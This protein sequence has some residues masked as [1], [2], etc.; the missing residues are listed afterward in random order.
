MKKKI[1]VFSML[2]ALSTAAYPSAWGDMRYIDQLVQDKEYDMAKEELLDFLGKYSDSKKY[3]PVALDRLAKLYYLDKNYEEARNYFKEYLKSQNLKED[4][5][6][7]GIYNLVR[8]DIELENYEEAKKYAD[9]ITS[10]KKYLAFFQ[11]A[12]AFYDKENYDDAQ[13]Y[14]RRLLKFD[15]QYYQEGLLYLSLTSYKKN[16]YLKSIV[17]GEEYLSKAEGGDKNISLMNF[18]LGSSHLKISDLPVAENYFKTIENESPDSEYADDSKYQLFKLYIEQKRNKEYLEY[19][20]KLKGTQYENQGYL[21]MAQLY[22]GKEEYL[23]AEEYYGVLVKKESNPETVYGYAQTLFKQ[24]KNQQALMELKKLKGTEYDS[25]YYYYSSYILYGDKKYKDVLALLGNYEKKGI[26][27]EYLKNIEVFMGTSAYETGAYDTAKKYFEKAYSQE[28]NKD[29][30]YNLALVNSKMKNLKELKEN[31]SDYMEKY[32]KEFKYKKNLYILLGNTYFD[33]GQLDGAEKLYEAF[34]KENYDEEIL[35]NLISVLSKQGNYSK[36]LLYLEKA[37]PSVENMYLKGVSHLGLN[38]YE[39]AETAFLWVISSDRATADQKERASFRLIKDY[40]AWEEYEKAVEYGEKHVEKYKNYYYESMDMMAIAYFKMGSY[41]N[42]RS[43]YEKFLKDPKWAEY[44]AFQIAETYYN[45]ENYLDA[46]KQYEKL[47]SKNG[48]YAEDSLYWIIS[49]DY[50]Q[51][52]FDQAFKKIE[53]LKQR[54]PKSKYEQEVSYIKGEIYIAKN[55]ADQA[56]AEYEKLYEKTKEFSIGQKTAEK[57]IG[58]HYGAGAYSKALEWSSKLKDSK[59]ADLWKAAV[60]QKQG[61]TEE[62]L[63]GYEK[64]A[65]DSEYGDKA[66]FALGE[67]YLEAGNTQEALS[68]Y[69][70]VLEFETSGLKDKALFKMGDLHLEN[71]NHME[72][73]K[74]FMKIRVL[75]EKSDLR[76]AAMIKI[77]KIYEDQKDEDKSLKTYLELYDDY[78]N[79]KNYP[80][81]IKKILVSY[82]KQ[83]K[84]EIAKNYYSELRKIDVK[85]AEQ[86]KKYFQN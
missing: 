79:S 14:F 9:Y 58:I 77:A 33:L 36:L 34:L 5:R 12:K 45:E 26:K 78:S 23:K 85:E 31:F 27:K 67:Y 40:L 61:K 28:P 13:I 83:N 53:E 4:E 81:F 32:P 59:K 42:S 80:Y 20:E 21:E 47:A 73:L 8:T 19:F 56:V 41:K 70:K 60:Y 74:D 39:Q 38:Q 69:D 37:S 76:E 29:N 72:A 68:H 71:G 57:L 54:F 46:K 25:E 62:S 48:S 86:F 3:Y 10:S 15:S 50:Y 22:F 30:L 16:E 84:N 11:V 65:K 2:L 63:K 82:L 52:N 51:G 49:I 64:L 17:F 6:Q 24:G 66:N 18:I 7:E 75:Y 44:G 43:L 35:N 55:Q 1:L